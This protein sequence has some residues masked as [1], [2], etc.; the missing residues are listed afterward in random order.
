MLTFWD[1]FGVSSTPHTT[2]PACTCLGD[3]QWAPRALELGHSQ[4]WS[5]PG[6]TLPSPNLFFQTA[7][8]QPT[9]KVTHFT[10][11]T[12]GNANM[13]SDRVKAKK[14]KQRKGKSSSRLHQRQLCVL[15]AS[16]RICPGSKG[17]P[18]GG[19]W[20]FRVAD[21]PVSWGFHLHCGPKEK[22]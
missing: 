14:R 13:D 2:T 22:W 11:K 8:L 7:K 4:D 9:S 1:A 6:L 12:H 21:A 10:E 15:P 17:L 18:L 16:W 3:R 20:G 19:E 5:D